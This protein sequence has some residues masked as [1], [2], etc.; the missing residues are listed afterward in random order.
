MK[1]IKS[2]LLTVHANLANQ[3]G[4]H[5]QSANVVLDADDVFLFHHRALLKVLPA[6]PAEPVDVLRP[7]GRPN[8]HTTTRFRAQLKV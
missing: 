8:S 1:K 2:I 6:A 4:G 7:G 5:H 3:T